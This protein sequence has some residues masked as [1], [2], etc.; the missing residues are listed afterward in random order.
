[1]TSAFADEASIVGTV[2][3]RYAEV[4]SRTNLNGEETSGILDTSLQTK[5]DDDFR[6]N[7]YVNVVPSSGI[8]DPRDW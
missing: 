7:L 8:H 6:L 1:M 4:L 2:R 3:F 5:C